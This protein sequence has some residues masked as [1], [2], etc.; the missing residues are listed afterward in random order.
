MAV[1]LAHRVF[2][3]TLEKIE[4]EITPVLSEKEGLAVDHKTN[5]VVHPNPCIDHNR[6]ARSDSRAS[7]QI[8]VGRVS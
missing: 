1:K 6:I 8:A 3:Y 4:L 7:G 5:N 2:G